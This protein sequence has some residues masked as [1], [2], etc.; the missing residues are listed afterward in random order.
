MGGEGAADFAQ[1]EGADAGGGGAE[2]GLGGGGRIP[3][4]EFAEEGVAAKDF[5]VRIAERAGEI[6]RRLQER[7]ADG[8]DEKRFGAGTANEKAG[9]DDVGAGAHEAAAGEVGEFERGIEGAVGVVGFEDDDTAGVIRA[10]DEGGVIAG[11]ERGENDGIAGAGG[12]GEGADAGGDGGDIRGGGG[13]LL[14]PIIVGGEVGSVCGLQCEN[15]VGETAGDIEG[16][17]AG[18]DG[19]EKHLFGFRAGD[20]KADD[21]GVGAGAGDAAGG[22]VDELGRGR[23]G[24][25]INRERDGV[26]VHRFVGRG[27]G[28]EVAAGVA[29]LGEIE[30]EARGV[31]DGEERLER[32]GTGGR[33]IPGVVVESGAEHR[34]RVVYGDGEACGAGDVD[35]RGRGLG[36]DDRTYDRGAIEGGGPGAIV[37]GE[38]IEVTD[39]A[40]HDRGDSLGGDGLIR[41]V[42]AE[43]VAEFVNEDTAQIEGGAAV[44][45]VGIPTLGGVHEHVGLGFPKCRGRKRDRERAVVEW[46]A[47]NGGRKEDVI[48]AVTE[49]G[50]G[51]GALGRGELDPG[52]MGVPL[53]ERGGGDGVPRGG[54]VEEGERRTRGA[55]GV[56]LKAHRDRARR[57][58]IS[59][60]IEG[61]AQRCTKGCEDE[62]QP[63]SV[64]TSAGHGEGRLREQP[65]RWGR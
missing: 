36:G 19:A 24:D 33:K 61:V 37:G 50:G 35:G 38:G 16:G 65:G 9:D 34:G 58:G 13:S 11:I 48:D 14:F 3:V 52:Q 40:V 32:G 23:D 64:E 15:R 8:A 26:A 12:E 18:A 22:D 28:E 27:G 45:A 54:G 43:D 53:V 25:G 44:P 39:G 63:K 6:E 7:G 10:T 29:E 41:M 42:E 46:I 4:V 55:G 5:E 30:I 2:G 47:V 1:G 49:R 17:E 31:V 51:D 20:G 59:D 56:E 21:H 62:T 57:P 60:Q